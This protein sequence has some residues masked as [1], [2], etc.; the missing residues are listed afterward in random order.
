M[1]VLRSLTENGNVQQATY[2][3]RV[4]GIPCAKVILSE[5]RYR[6]FAPRAYLPLGYLT[7]VPDLTLTVGDH[8]GGRSV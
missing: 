2:I 8:K 3:I 7:S 1:N 4:K 5:S 6:T